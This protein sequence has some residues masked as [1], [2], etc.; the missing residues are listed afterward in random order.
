MFVILLYLFIAL[1]CIGLII[2][3]IYGIHQSFTN[4]LTGFFMAPLQILAGIII[5]GGL[6]YLLFYTPIEI[7]YNK[8]KYISELLDFNIIFY[9][10]L[11]TFLVF[12]ILQFIIINIIT[13]KN[14]TNKINI[15]NMILPLGLKNLLIILLIMIISAICISYDIVFLI[16]YFNENTVKSI[17]ITLGILVKLFFYML[18]VVIYLKDKKRNITSATSHDKR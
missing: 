15:L 14:A 16:K 1:Y 10:I 4:G 12:I 11:I 2:G 9:I 17:F 3:I 8:N 18:P 5:G 6:S 7:F 13:N